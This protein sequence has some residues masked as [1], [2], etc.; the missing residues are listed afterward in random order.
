[1]R[2]TLEM[3]GISDETRIRVFP[4]FR[5]ALDFL[6]GSFAYG[7]IDAV[8]KSANGRILYEEVMGFRREEEKEESLCWKEYGF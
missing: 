3:T 7:T 6:V 2:I 1:M 8:I 5:K 4:S